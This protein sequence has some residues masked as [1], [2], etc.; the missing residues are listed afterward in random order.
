M[1]RQADTFLARECAG[2]SLLSLRDCC[3]AGPAGGWVRPCVSPAA[4]AAHSSARD[5]RARSASGP[6]GVGMKRPRRLPNAARASG[7]RGLRRDWPPAAPAD[8]MPPSR[9]AVGSAN[10]ARALARASRTCRWT[11][12][13]GVGVKSAPRA[14]GAIPAERA[15]TER[16]D[17][18]VETLAEHERTARGRGTARVRTPGCASSVARGG[19]SEG[20]A[21]CAARAT[22]PNP[23][24]KK[25]AKPPP[26]RRNSYEV[27]NQRKRIVFRGA[28]GAGGPRL[29]GS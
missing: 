22:A 6:L 23:R 1:A 24:G 14:I 28:A 2:G 29:T 21:R 26:A 3:C 16:P 19:V 15:G 8:R 18:R 13:Q 4:A 7:A 27:A 20:C 5:R 9:D 12:N 25:G 17:W 11:R 10:E